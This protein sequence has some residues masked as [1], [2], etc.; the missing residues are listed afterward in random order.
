MQTTCKQSY[1]VA[2]LSVDHDKHYA[3]CSRDSLYDLNNFTG[4][5]DPVIMSVTVPDYEIQQVEKSTLSARHTRV[6]M[7]EVYLI[8]CI[9]FCPH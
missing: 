1:E 2:L 8:L 5:H 9:I 4:F 7:E 3:G 6:N